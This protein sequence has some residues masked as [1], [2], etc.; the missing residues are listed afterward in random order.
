MVTG[1]KMGW[2]QLKKSICQAAFY[3]L[4]LPAALSTSCVVNMVDD[5]YPEGAWYPGNAFQKTLALKSGGTLSLENTNGNIVIRGWDKEKVELMAVEKRNPPLSPKIYFYGSHA[6]EPKIDLQASNEVIAIKTVSSDKEDEFRLVHYE[7]SVPRSIK[8]ENIRNGQGKIEISDVFGG[9]QIGQ[10]EGNIT[11]KN[12]SGS[13]DIA[14]GSGSVEAEV[15]DIRPED[16]VQIKSEKGDILLYLE[17]GVTAQ[18]EA[19]APDGEIS[20]DFDFNQ[21]LPAKTLSAKL[22]E[23]KASLVLT[24]LH[25]DI[26]IRKVE[27]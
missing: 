12:F 20:S 14:L 3:F 2:K 22:G 7:L 11:I 17:P 24:A 10:K 27:D 4:L 25:G 21:A 26:K 8:L 18:V 13:V 6:L 5:Q 9:V 23:G 15:L 1:F 16:H 19:N